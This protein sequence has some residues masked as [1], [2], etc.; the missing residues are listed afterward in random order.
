MD[1]AWED[2]YVAS[3][4]GELLGELLS[5]KSFYK[6]KDA[7]VPSEQWRQKCRLDCGYQGDCAKGRTPAQSLRGALASK[8]LP[9]VVPIAGKEVTKQVARSHATDRPLLV[10]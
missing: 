10:T 1:L 2:G 3:F 8:K 6:L 9:P 7:Q 5:R 4:N